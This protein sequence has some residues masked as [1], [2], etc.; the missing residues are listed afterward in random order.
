MSFFMISKII[1]S[2][3]AALSLTSCVN[4]GEDNNSS[5]S[6]VIS[7]TFDF[8]AMMANYV[9]ELIIPSYQNFSNEIPKVSLNATSQF[10]FSVKFL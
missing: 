9:D 4:N 6:A 1:L 5:A 2:L 3:F 7:E 10:G 8:T